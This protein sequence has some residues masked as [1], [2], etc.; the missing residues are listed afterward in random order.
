ME[1]LLMFFKML[2]EKLFPNLKKGDLSKD[3]HKIKIKT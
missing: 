1:A 3:K 2:R